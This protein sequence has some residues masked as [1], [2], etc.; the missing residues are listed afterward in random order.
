MIQDLGNSVLVAFS[1]LSKIR[2]EHDLAFRSRLQS[3]FMSVHLR[4]GVSTQKLIEEMMEINRR[5]L[6]LSLFADTV[7]RALEALPAPESE[8]LRLRFMRGRTFQEIALLQSVSLRTAFRRFDK[9]KADLTRIL[10]S[11]GL[12][13]KTFERDYMSDP[14]VAAVCERLDT[15]AYFTCGTACSADF[16]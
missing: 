15:G 16:E 6:R 9:A 2:K 10:K 7:E 1:T 13:E 4:C 8:I 14:A 3:S 5:K 12:D 11:A